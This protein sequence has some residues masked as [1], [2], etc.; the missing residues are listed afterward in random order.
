MSTDF[1][2]HEREERAFDICGVEN[3]ILDFLVKVDDSRLG[4]LGL[5]KG[6]MKLVDTDEQA[7]ILEHVGGMEPDIEAGGSCANVLRMASRMGCRTSYSSAVGP[8]LHGSLFSYELNEAG[9]KDRLAM[10]KGATGTSVVLV[11]DDGERTM[12]THLGVCR[13]YGKEHLPEADIRDCRIFFTTGYMWDTPNQIE[14]IEMALSK[15]HEAGAKVAVDLADPF[16]VDRSKD[17]LSELIRDG[18]DVVFANTEEGRMMTG[19]GARDAAI[20]MA[21]TVEISVVT[22]GGNGSYIAS[23]NQVIHVPSIPTKVIDT[24]GAGD[25]YAAGF[26]AGLAHGKSLRRCGEIATLMASDAIAHVGVRLSP[27]TDAR[28]AQMLAD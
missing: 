19:F 11:S 2:N 18:M 7:V 17:R 9:V 5:T 23:G 21:R 8:D 24:T 10:V 6:T 4:E 25:C 16:A 12:N 22:D 14:A 26:L 20:A 28:V 13:E 15:A 1:W 3:A 27:E